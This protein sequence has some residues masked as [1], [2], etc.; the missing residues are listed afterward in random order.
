MTSLPITYSL[1]AAERNDLKLPPL[2]PRGS[3]R[4]PSSAL[5]TPC[6]R[7]SAIATSFSPE[8]NPQYDISYRNRSQRAIG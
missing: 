6:A 4:L 2:R 5:S 3:R 7:L 8:R 1:T